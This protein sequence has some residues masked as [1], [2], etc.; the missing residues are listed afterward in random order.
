MEKDN[1]FDKA[2]Q[3]RDHKIKDSLA[4]AAIETTD[5]LDLCWD[6]ARAVFGTKAKPEHAL[7]L[8]PVFMQQAEEKRR[9]LRSG[10]TS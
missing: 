6:A 4:E 3:A 5:T 10:D 8:L 1:P 2:L 9:R 7:A